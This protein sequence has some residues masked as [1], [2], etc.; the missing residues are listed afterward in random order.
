V[1]RED[2][3]ELIER[4]RNNL[5]TRQENSPLPWGTSDS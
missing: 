5:S 4:H 3:P 2:G 1:N